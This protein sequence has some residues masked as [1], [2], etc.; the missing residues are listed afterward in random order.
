MIV[1]VFSKGVKQE[2]LTVEITKETVRIW[3]NA[4]KYSLLV[5][6]KYS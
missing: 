3:G 6:L 1:T 5:T 4:A 2:D